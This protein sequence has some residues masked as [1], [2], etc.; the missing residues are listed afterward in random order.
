M[1][2]WSEWNPDG[3]I[4]S[5]IRR[6]ARHGGLPEIYELVTNAADNSS[7]VISGK[8]SLRLS[9]GMASAGSR[10]TNDRDGQPLSRAIP[11]VY[12]AASCAFISANLEWRGAERRR[13]QKFFGETRQDVAWGHHYVAPWNSRNIARIPITQ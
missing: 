9:G 4:A 3:S 12:S 10:G 2:P 11:R 13:G 6:P 5:L 8:L 1:F 7:A